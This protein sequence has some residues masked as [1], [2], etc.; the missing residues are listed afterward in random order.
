MLELYGVSVSF[1]GLTALDRIDLCLPAGGRHALIGP[2]GAGKSTLLHT[3]AG[4][5][6]PTAGRVAPAGR[7]AVAGRVV[8][9]GRDVTPLPAH[10]RAR[11]GMA[12]T[13]Q[14]PALLRRHT[15]RDNVAA[16]LW[17]RQ[18]SELA[19]R[20]ARRRVAAEAEALLERVGL[21]GTGGLVAGT[22]AHAQQRQ[23]EFAIALAMRPRLLLLDEPAA[24]LSSAERVR[25]AGLVRDLPATLT[26][27]LVDHDLDLVFDLATSVTVLHLG[28][29]VT[30]GPPEQVRTDPRVDEIYPG[31]RAR[32]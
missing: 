21:G 18:P 23:L 14:H 6:V 29:M 20:S 4:T 10:R 13:F 25:L 32:P 24:G 28:R 19:R 9:A 27:L 26:V 12:R 2:N 3:I 15:V 11:L 31:T 5:V 7:V 22:L 30:T 8:L 16:A 1:G 17:R